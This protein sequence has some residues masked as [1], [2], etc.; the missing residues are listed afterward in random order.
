MKELERRLKQTVAVF[1]E[2]SKS[3]NLVKYK[4]FNKMINFM[5]GEKKIMNETVLMF[6]F[7]LNLYHH[8]SNYSQANLMRNT[9]FNV[10]YRVYL[11]KTQDVKKQFLDKVENVFFNDIENV[12]EIIFKMKEEKHMPEDALERLLSLQ[13]SPLDFLATIQFFILLTSTFTFF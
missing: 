8:I 13:N 2:K 3:K 11:E 7:I 5:L 9:R 12:W 6:S 4:E 1:D 10:L